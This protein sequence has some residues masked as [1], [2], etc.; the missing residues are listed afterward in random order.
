DDLPARDLVAT[1]LAG[2]PRRQAALDAWWDL[3]TALMEVHCEYDVGSERMLAEQGSVADGEIRLG[4]QAYRVVVLPR[5]VSMRGRT[6]ELLGRFV[7]AGG[8]I[9]VTG[10]TPGYLD[11]S[12]S[13]IARSFFQRDFIVRC[14]PTRASLAQCLDKVNPP[15]IGITTRGGRNIA[16]VYAHRRVLRGRDLCFFASMDRQRTRH[17]T[18][19]VPDAG[20]VELWDAM[21]GDVHPLPSRTHEGRRLFDLDFPPGASFLVSV[22]KATKGATPLPEPPGPRR[23]KKIALAPIWRKRRLGPNALVLDFCKRRIGRGR[24]S[25]RLPVHEAQ[26][27][28]CERFDLPFDP[29]NRGT[30]FW[31]AYQEMERLGEKARVRLR[32][33]FVSELSE[34]AAG[35]LKLVVECGERFEAQVNGKAVA[36]DGWWRDPAF[37][38]AEIGHAVQ[39]GENRID[40][41]IEFRQDVELEP[42]F[43]IGDFALDKDLVLVDEKPTLK[44]GDWT[45][46]GYPFYADAMAYEQTVHLDAVPETASLCFEGLDAIVSRV[47]VNG[48]DAG[49]VFAEPLEAD[50]ADLLREGDNKIVVEVYPSLHNLIGPTHYGGEPSRITGPGHF[51]AAW[52]DEYQLQPYGIAGDV[53]LEI[54]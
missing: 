22:G 45:A 18:I 38:T 5:M 32:Y 31:K 14:R 17:A 27:A 44:T 3:T 51:F 48:E 50:V 29:G 52:T 11:G 23:R 12:R 30:Q 19:A 25:A 20:E 54:G 21:T 24:W 40:L 26:R 43:L 2:E 28:A 49:L 33:E 42:S 41:A 13:R 6:L 4:E 16:S 53:W 35:G 7:E 47:E 46:Q 39:E 1:A 8:T 9:I 37:H 10:E 36:F 15:S 34:E